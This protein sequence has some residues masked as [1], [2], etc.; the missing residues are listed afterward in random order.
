VNAKKTALKGK[1]ALALASE[2]DELYVAKGKNLVYIDLRKEQPD[3]KRLLGL[4]LGPTGN[5]RAPTLRI[6]RKLIVGFDFE[7]YQRLFG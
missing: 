7:T 6:G 3:Q 2:S 4:L 1:D 5:L